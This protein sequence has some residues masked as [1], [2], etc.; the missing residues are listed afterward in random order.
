M[1]AEESKE[2]LLGNTLQ[3]TVEAES[4]FDET[5]ALAAGAWMV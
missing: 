2:S 4:G 3:L 1:A 5:F